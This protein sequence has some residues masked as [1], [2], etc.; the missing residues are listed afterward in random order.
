M[1]QGKTN[2]IEAI[3]YTSSLTNKIPKVNDKL[4]MTYTLGLAPVE[5]NDLKYNLLDTPGYFDFRG[6]VIS[7]LVQSMQLLL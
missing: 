5:Y 6:E 1:D 2:L 3:A 7:S 4:N